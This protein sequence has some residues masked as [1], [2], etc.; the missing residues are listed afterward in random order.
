MALP[1][2]AMTRS[3][4]LTLLLSL[5]ALSAPALAEEITGDPAAGR[6]LAQMWCGN[7]HAF[8]GAKQATST[9]APSF[10]AVAAN[11]AL[12]RE[13]LRAFLQHK[14]DRMPD[15]HLSNSEMDDLIAFV[16]SPGSG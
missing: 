4:V 11:K 16:L 3:Y 15:L 7:C 6:K 13:V 2:A 8:N 1:A 9:G 10:S 5:I 12:T 14:H